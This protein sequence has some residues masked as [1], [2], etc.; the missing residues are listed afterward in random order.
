MVGM[1]HQRCHSE[2]CYNECWAC[3]T[4]AATTCCTTA[5]VPMVD[6]S[7]QCCHGEL[8]CDGGRATPALSRRASQRLRL[9]WRWACRTSASTTDLAAMVGVPLQRR[10]ARRSR[11]G[12]WACRTSA[13]TIDYVAMNGGRAAPVLLRR[14]ARRTRLR[15][16]AC[17]TSANTANYVAMVGVRTM[18]VITTLRRKKIRHDNL[19]L[20]VKM[21][22]R[23]CTCLR[24]ICS[25]SF[26]K[27]GYSS[28]KPAK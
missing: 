1:P 23:P 11:L 25:K 6:G 9:Q 19:F 14:A 21:G 12:C 10:A 20:Q 26:E 24:K 2:L 15:W 13:S 7:N 4:S 3:R 16:W 5:E 28:Q 17:C 8:C 27:H 18:N 22:L